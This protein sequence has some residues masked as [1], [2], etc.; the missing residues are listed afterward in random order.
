M[1]VA[2]TDLS[3]NRNP[4]LNMVLLLHAFNVACFILVCFWLP[5]S[6]ELKTIKSLMISEATAHGIDVGARVAIVYK[7]I[8]WGSILV[9]LFYGLFRYLQT[10]IQIR[11][12]Q[13]DELILFSATGICLAFLQAMG[14]ETM[15]VLKIVNGI[16]LAAPPVVAAL[17]AL[18]IFCRTLKAES[19]FFLMPCGRFAPVVRPV[20]FMG[21]P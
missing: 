7:L 12:L 10:R 15:T 8:G 14:L 5:V 17:Q 18:G 3:L 6:F 2:K 16:F 19:S 11:F 20:L 21:Q 9:L 1:S 4:A 13:E